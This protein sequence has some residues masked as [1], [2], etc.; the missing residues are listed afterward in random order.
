MWTACEVFNKA[1][2]FRSFG[3]WSWMKSN[4]VGL[5]IASALDCGHVDHAHQRRSSGREAC[6]PERVISSEAEGGQ[7]P[8][9]LSLNFDTS[10][11]RLEDNVPCYSDLSRDLLHRPLVLVE[12]VALQSAESLKSCSVKV[13]SYHLRMSKRRENVLLGILTRK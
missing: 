3:A 9:T 11:S 1:D 13:L 5:V 7:M 6:S 12:V 10:V 2:S 8:Y 4:A